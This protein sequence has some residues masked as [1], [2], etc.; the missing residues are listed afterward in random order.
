MWQISSNKSSDLE[1][2]VKF[3]LSSLKWFNLNDFHKVY[4]VKCDL[5]DCD[6]NVCENLISTYDFELVDRRNINEIL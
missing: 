6:D 1:T 4:F 5:E 3:A 2:D